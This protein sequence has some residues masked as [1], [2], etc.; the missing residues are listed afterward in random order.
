MNDKVLKTLEFDKIRQQ[1]SAHADSPEGKQLACEL[2][3]SVLI[4]EIRFNQNETA[5]AVH[6]I[7]QYGSLSFSGV[8]NVEG[9]LKRL[10]IAAALSAAE[11]LTITGILTVSS[12]AKAYAREAENIEDAL[13]GYFQ[14]IDPLTPIRQELLR[15]ILSEDEIADDASPELS[16]LRH[17]KKGLTEKIH[18]SLSNILN[19]SRSMLQESVITQRDGRYC[20]PVR[21]EYKASFPG[22]VHDQSSTGATLFIEPMSIVRLNNEIKELEAAEKQEI[23]RILELLSGKLM[24]HTSVI[25]KN[26]AILTHLDLVF[27]KAKY[28]NALRATKP[29]FNDRFYIN[30]LQGRHPLLN[31]ETVV[32]VNIYLGDSF[33]MLIITGPNTGGKTVCLKTVGLFQLMGQAGLFIPAKDGSEL[34]VFN[35][36]FADIGDEQS[37][38]QNLSTFS[39]HMTNTVRILEQADPR[40]LC[41]FDELGAGTDPTEGAALAMA[42]LNTLHT[43]KTRTV[44]TTHYAEI[45]VYAL[46]TP[47]IENACCEFDVSTLSP[48]Y[49]LLIG[50]P[51]K[52]NAFAISKKLGLPDHIIEDAK[53]RLESEDIKFED[54]ITSLEES[55]ITIERER[56]EVARYKQEIEDFKQRARENSRG[57]EKGREKILQR[58]REE[59]A[60]I[61]AEAK[62]TAD[63]IVKELRRQ[64][65]NGAA[66]LEAEKTRSELN[67]KLKK[68]QA[69]LSIGTNKGPSRPVSAKNLRIGDTVRVA[70]MNMNAVVSTLPDHQNMVFV[71][72]GIIRMR[73]SI[74]DIEFVSA[75]VS[76]DSAKPVKSS[77]AA[78]RMSK[79]MGISPEINLI[80]MTTAEAIPELQ[81]YLDDAYLG[82]LPTCR[83]V[84]GR[85]TGALKKA[86]HTQLKKLKYVDSF[87]LGEFG[88]GQDGV[89]IVTF[90]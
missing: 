47:G 3:P 64:E 81:K 20:L 80:G 25:R 5:A 31:P 67:R 24:P 32:P 13:S 22:M 15:C 9:S 2:E 16:S 68:T 1:L 84:H 75:A 34:A 17:K 88:E 61:L 62:E 85:G 10:E 29:D 78:L 19:S 77:H 27:A 90:K 6:R 41:L 69:E 63:S 49:R 56:A 44:A 23:A 65:Q 79:T 11:L 53:S 12:R 38:E 70:S 35:D 55:R 14:D 8:H 48:T 30:I 76:A 37:I 18:S 59:A 26:M 54:V 46:S 45:K 4:D 83:I 52:S 86:V 36:I 33:S 89:T 87:R 21:A 71:T 74:R 7:E 50:V 73:V 58:A 42:I 82:H 57:V 60:Q 43:M 28:A 51:G 72:A 40:S 66:T 39:A